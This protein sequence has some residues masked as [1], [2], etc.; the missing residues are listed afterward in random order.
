MQTKE[1]VVRDPDNTKV[2]A[3]EQRVTNVETKVDKIDGRL[4]FIEKKVIDLL[5]TTIGY[6]KQLLKIK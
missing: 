5:N 6:L 2:E 1:T 4:L 3:V